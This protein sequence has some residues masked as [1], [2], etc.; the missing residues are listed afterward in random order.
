MRI[1]H[2]VA[3]FGLVAATIAALVVTSPEARAANS[4]LNDPALQINDFTCLLLDGDGNFV[5]TDESHTVITSSGNGNFRCSATDVANSTGRA[6]IYTD[7]L[8]NTQAGQTTD[9]RLVVSASGNAV[10]TCKVH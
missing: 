8:C 10:L 2:A 9:S 7:F 4:T 5:I 1:K 6:V 3:A